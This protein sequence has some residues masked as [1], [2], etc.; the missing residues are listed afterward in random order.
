MGG[1][2]EI[3]EKI[4]DEKSKGNSKWKVKGHQK[5]VLVLIDRRLLF[6]EAQE[7]SALPFDVS[8]EVQLINLDKSWLEKPTF[9]S[10]KETAKLETHVFRLK[11]KKDYKNQQKLIDKYKNERKKPFKTSSRK[12]SASNH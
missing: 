10:L 7:N 1:A 9:E 3:L 5:G 2:R 12:A 4:K 11:K 6:V 8:V